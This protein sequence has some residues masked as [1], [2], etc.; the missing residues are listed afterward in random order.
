MFSFVLSHTVV[1]RY[2]FLFLLM[3]GSTPL[4]QQAVSKPRAWRPFSCEERR[5]ERGWFHL[6]SVKR[7]VC[8]RE[9]N[10]L[11][12]VSSDGKT[13]TQQEVIIPLNTM[14]SS[15]SKP[16]AKWAE[17]ERGGVPRTRNTHP[18]PW[19]VRKIFKLGGKVGFLWALKS[20][21]IR[22]Y[23]SELIFL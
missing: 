22:F 4:P 19:I 16:V 14:K 1:S 13:G 9:K 3:N 7:V 18:L 8:G 23:N 6:P 17:T 21:L 20:F 12:C 11:F 2:P 15:S 10:D 5:E